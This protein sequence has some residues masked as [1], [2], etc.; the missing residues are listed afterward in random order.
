L[1][2]LALL[3]SLFVATIVIVQA[4]DITLTEGNEF[5]IERV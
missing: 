3:L 4:N 2:R 5:M 1:H